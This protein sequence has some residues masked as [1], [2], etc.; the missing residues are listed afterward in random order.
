M[1]TMVVIKKWV[2]SAMIV[3]SR[4]DTWKSFKYKKKYTYT[5]KRLK[6]VE[7]NENLTDE[8]LLANHGKK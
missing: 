8:S 3:S 1:R 2:T 5:Y 4:G 6:L 7:F